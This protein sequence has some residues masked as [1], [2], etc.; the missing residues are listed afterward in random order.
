[1]PPHLARYLVCTALLTI[2]CRAADV[3][4]SQVG[5]GVKFTEVFRKEFNLGDHK[6]TLVRVRKPNLPLLPAPPA[7]PPLTAEQQATSDRMAQK[8]Y[9][10]LNITATVYLCPRPI[11]EIRWRDDT[12]TREYRAWSNV[13][14]RY[15]TRLP[16][17]ETERTVYQWFPFVE[18]FSLSDWPSDQKPPIPQGLNLSA[19]DAEYIVEGS[20]KDL[21]DQEATLTGLDY[22]HAYYQLHY[23]ELKADYE[24]RMADNAAREKELREHPPVKPDTTLRFWPIRSRINPR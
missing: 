4:A 24:K 18:A 8:A 23:A 9:A 20:A 6:F 5:D 1:M 3:P 10:S 16:Y 14:F 21:A 22:L 19:T 13:D 11:T 17:L 7:P 12:G 2:L 15:L